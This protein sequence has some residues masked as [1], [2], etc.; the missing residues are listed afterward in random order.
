[1]PTARAA[2]AAGPPRSLPIDAIE[3]NREQPRIHFDGAKLDE[4]AASIRS[5]GLIQPLV[6]SEKAGEPGRYMLI[7][8]E[9]RWRASRL[10]GLDVVPV[11]VR[12][13]EDDQARLEL[14]LVENLQRADLDPIEE[15]DAYRAL[16]ERF[17]LSHEAVA[18]RVGKARTTVTN[19]LRLLRLPPAVHDF[20]RDGRLT[21]GQARPLL[22]LAD[23]DQQLALARRAVEEGLT[24]RA[25]EALAAAAS[26]GASAPAKARKAEEAD[27]NTRA[28]ADQLTRHLQTPV[29]I[30]RRRTGGFV[31]IHFHSEE[32]LIRLYEQ[33]TDD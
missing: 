30:V 31:R 12:E 5:Q 32:E 19:A 17:G 16:Q 22:G 20:L 25:L 33:L 29:D 21:P 9:R 27:A 15:A 8:G 14:A 6:V 26:R 7:A 10:A 18:Q 13:V 4:L 24:A 1:A 11:V 2:P 23:V 3:P 28:A